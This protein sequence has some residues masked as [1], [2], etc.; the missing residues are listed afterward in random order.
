VV[1]AGLSFGGGVAQ[2]YALRYP[3]HVERLLLVASVGSPEPWWR[4][5]PVVTRAFVAFT[6]WLLFSAESQKVVRPTWGFSSMVT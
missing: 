5:M 2:H 1:L 3:E 6:R 4:P